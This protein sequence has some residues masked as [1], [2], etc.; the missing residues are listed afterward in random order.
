MLRAG[1]GFPALM[2]LLGHTDPE[3]TMRYVDVALT[4]LQREFQL[5][6]AKP[7]HLIPQ[8]KAQLTSV[9][10]GLTGV[11]DSIIAAQHVLEMFRRTLPDDHARRRLY[12][13]SNRLTKILA[14]A[15]KLATS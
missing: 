11:L 14:E 9:R 15:R 8:P 4:D 3:M 10:S 5:A 12:R 1:V 2:K 6:R 13:L 7:R